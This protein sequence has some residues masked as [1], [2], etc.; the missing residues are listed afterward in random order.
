MFPPFSSQQQQ[1]QQLIDDGCW[2]WW[3]VGT[4]LPIEKWSNSDATCS[5]DPV[6]SLKRQW[7]QGSKSKQQ[8]IPA[9]PNVTRVPFLWQLWIKY[10][11]FIQ[12]FVSCL[13][14]SL[15][16]QRKTKW[17]AGRRHLR[18]VWQHV[19][20]PDWCLSYMARAF[21]S[22]LRNSREQIYTCICWFPGFTC[23]PSQSEVNFWKVCKQ[24]KQ[25]KTDSIALVG[26]SW[27]SWV[28]FKWQGL[29]S[30][31]GPHM[32]FKNMDGLISWRSR[33]CR[34]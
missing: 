26:F 12:V 13:M 10:S 14:C 23:F 34:S 16:S 9:V 5:S 32:T 4:F 22:A 18:R 8:H 20:K 24:K 30:F 6:C 25:K 7:V 27:I 1:Q 33:A 28:L 21:I 2:F 31:V 17:R 19:N 29:I 11:L 3:C 15:A